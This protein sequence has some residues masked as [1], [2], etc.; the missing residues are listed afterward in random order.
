MPEVKRKGK[1]RETWRNVWQLTKKDKNRQHFRIRQKWTNKRTIFP[2][3]PQQYT[4]AS[5]L[6]TCCKRWKAPVSMRRRNRSSWHRHFSWYDLCRTLC[7]GHL[8]F[9][10]CNGT[11]FSH[12]PSYIRESL[13][14]SR[15]LARSSDHCACKRLTV[16]RHLRHFKIMMNDESIEEERQCSVLDHDHTSHH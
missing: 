14:H 16:A 9:Q 10:N 7:R 11:T 2:I 6:R 3:P 12:R 1:H 5:S 8:R 4:S 13:R 15:G